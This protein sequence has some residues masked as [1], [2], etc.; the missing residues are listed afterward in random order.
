[1]SNAPILIE[2]DGEIAT[3]VLNNPSKR[4]ALTLAAW[5]DLAD[6]IRT[7]NA[8]LD[9]RCVIMRGA[10]DQAFAAGADIAG[11]PDHRANADQAYEYGEHVAAAL[12]LVRECLHPTIAMIR[13]ACTGGGL[14][15]AACC[16]LRIAS[17]TARIGVPVNRIGHGFAA[18]EMKPV[19]DLV[20]PAVVLELLLE[21]CIF[22]AETALQK[23]ILTR[24]V[25]DAELES[26]VMQTAARIA[27]G[28][29][30]A[31]R[32]TKQILNRLL[33]DPN[34]LSEQEV[35]DSYTPCDSND[36]AE[37]V[38]A[39]LEKRKPNFTGR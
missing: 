3:I 25:D 38:A 32:M 35:R 24:V 36:Y 9:V 18:A 28:A 17:T 10:G 23:G 29:P 21:G 6:A 26:D 13:G 34:P 15:I 37:G 12:G 20:G 31:A 22:G 5:D 1:M 30:L 27:A 8:D 4:N 33:R 19:L 7:L 2:R 39:F 14:E 11:F 16:D